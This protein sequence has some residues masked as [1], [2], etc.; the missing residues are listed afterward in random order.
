M[1]VCVCVCMLCIVSIPTCF[2]PSA[3]SS[4]SLNLVLKLQNH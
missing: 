2:D 1:C 3:S 4:G